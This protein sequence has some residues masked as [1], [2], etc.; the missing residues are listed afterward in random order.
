MNLTL[1]TLMSYDTPLF[2]GCVQTQKLSNL[3]FRTQGSG[4]HLPFRAHYFYIMAFRPHSESSHGLLASPT[5]YS[6]PSGLTH[7]LLMAFRPHS[8]RAQSSL[9][10]PRAALQPALYICM[11]VHYVLY[12][13]RYKQG[14]RL[15][16]PLIKHMN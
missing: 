13:N 15:P 5:A 3:S 16:G 6:W 10:E 14:L 7:S 12:C 8:Q 9:I 1:Y 2:G 11:S 4:W